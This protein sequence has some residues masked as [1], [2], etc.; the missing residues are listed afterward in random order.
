[1]YKLEKDSDFSSDIQNT[2]LINVIGLNETNT[3][4]AFFIKLLNTKHKTKQNCL[5]TVQVG[6]SSEDRDTVNE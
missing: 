1:M 6:L 4:I 3:C 2:R 5:T